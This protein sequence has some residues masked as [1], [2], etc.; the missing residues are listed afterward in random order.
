MAK[1]LWNIL[2]SVFD[3][4][5]PPRTHFEIVSKL[6]PETYSNIPK[7]HEMVGAD[8]I[9]P[10]FTYG[11]KRVRAIIWELKYRENTLPLDHI[12]LLLYEE[13]FALMS[14]ILLFDSK[15]EFLLIPIP[16]STQ[17]RKERGY[18]QSE[19]L[20]KSVLEH[21]IEHALL[22]APQWFQKIRETE[23]QSHSHSKTERLQNLVGCFFADPRIAGKYV[24]LIDDVVTTGSTLS[25]ARKTLRNAGSR[26]V[27]AFTIAH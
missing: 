1:Q 12:G 8:W 3:Y 11:D 18:N 19:Y 15:A 26:E 4:I 25:E 24:I 5:L 14:D 16:I 10:L 23:R 22:Y 9:H 20:A 13:I 17:R 6:N 2:K 27:F 7:A 21:D